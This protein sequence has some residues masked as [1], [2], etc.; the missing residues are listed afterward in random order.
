MLAGLYP[1]VRRHFLQFGPDA[2][3][4]FRYLLG[5]FRKDNAPVIQEY[6]AKFGHLQAFHD[7]VLFNHLDSIGFIPDLYVLFP[8]GF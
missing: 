6:L 1:K 2:V 3:F 5:M 4:D 7:P 8:V